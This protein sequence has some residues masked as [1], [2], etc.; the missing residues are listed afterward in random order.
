[1][2]LFFQHKGPGRIALLRAYNDLHSKAS[3]LYKPHPKTLEAAFLD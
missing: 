1:M 2:Q 3:G